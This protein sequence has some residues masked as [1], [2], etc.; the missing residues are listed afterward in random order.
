MIT[1]NMVNLGE[2]INSEYPNDAFFVD[3]VV[4]SACLLK[5]GTQIAI[6]PNLQQPKFVL[7]TLTETIFQIGDKE[8][9]VNSDNKLHSHDVVMEK[10]FQ[11][12]WKFIKK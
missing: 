9:L 7:K 11:N 4:M 5:N 3:D 10:Y 6:G 1:P 2:L 12:Y 8:A